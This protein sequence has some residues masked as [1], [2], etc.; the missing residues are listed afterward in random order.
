MVEARGK[1]Q[2]YD[3]KSLQRLAQSG[4]FQ[5]SKGILEKRPLEVRFVGGERGPMGDYSRHRNQTRRKSIV[6]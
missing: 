1:G 5:S 4:Q 3:I 2:E 6:P